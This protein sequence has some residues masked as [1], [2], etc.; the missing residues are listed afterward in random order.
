MK[1]KRCNWPREWVG[2][3]IDYLLGSGRLNADFS[4]VTVG[5]KKD[6]GVI[7]SV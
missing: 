1:T 4:I 5:S 3:R 6:N 7:F 2:R